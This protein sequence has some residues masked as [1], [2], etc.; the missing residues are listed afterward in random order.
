MVSGIM[1]FRCTAEDEGIDMKV[2]RNTVTNNLSE[3]E[4]HILKHNSCSHGVHALLL[5]KEL[6]GHPGC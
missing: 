5:K 4:S 3:V 1:V 6:T 2:A